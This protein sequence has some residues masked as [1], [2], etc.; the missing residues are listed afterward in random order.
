MHLLECSVCR[1]P[2]RSDGTRVLDALYRGPAGHAP[3][4]ECL[5]CWLY[6][7]VASRRGEADLKTVLLLL[8]DGRSVVEISQIIG[9][10]KR[11]I[12]RWLAP[13][14][15]LSPDEVSRMA[16]VRVRTVRAAKDH[17]GRPVARRS[18]E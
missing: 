17:R 4:D 8:S 7:W 9:R 18:H 1:G 14:R 3:Q 11:T 12:F 5:E 16:G 15:L 6:E 2:K 13:L 10:H